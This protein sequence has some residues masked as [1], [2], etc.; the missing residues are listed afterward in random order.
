[1]TLQ[2]YRAQKII[3]WR[4]KKIIKENE[5]AIKKFENELERLEREIREEN[6][7]RMVGS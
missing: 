6:K 7:I 4:R 3:E 1:M 5:Y 2:S